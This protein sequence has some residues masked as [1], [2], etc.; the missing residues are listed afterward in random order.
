MPIKI[1]SHE[2]RKVFL[3]KLIK[4]S[5]QDPSLCIQCGNCSAVCPMVQ[6]MEINPR[7][8]MRLSQLGME[9]R[10][11]TLKG[12]WVCA[13]CHSC[14]DNCPRGIKIQN[15]LEALRLMTLRQNIDYLEPS[16][17]FVQTVDDY[18]QIALVAAFRKMSS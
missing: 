2:S 15:L 14:G 3:D 5:G 12:Y 8:I 17:E 13:S 4:M 1:S 7:M 10:L 16:P 6:H 11:K 18:P 9:D